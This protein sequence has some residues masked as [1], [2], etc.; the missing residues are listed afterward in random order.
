MTKRNTYDHLLILIRHLAIELAVN[1]EREDDESQWQ[2]ESVSVLRR[3]LMTMQTHGRHIPTPV[4]LVLIR[5]GQLPPPLPVLLDAT[6]AAAAVGISRSA[7]IAMARRRQ[8][9]GAQKISG[10]WLFDQERLM[11]SGISSDLR[12]DAADHEI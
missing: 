9:N 7:L 8:V 10:R 5:A 6:T 4:K 12:E 1:L 2:P 3:T 11:A